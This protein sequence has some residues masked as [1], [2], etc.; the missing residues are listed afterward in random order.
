MKQNK[1]T[2]IKIVLF[3]TISIRHYIIYM[4]CYVVSW[5]HVESYQRNRQAFCMRSGKI[6]AHTSCSH[7]YQFSRNGN[8]SNQYVS[9]MAWPRGEIMQANRRI[10]LFT[11][12]SSTPCIVIPNFLS[13]G[14]GHVRKISNFKNSTIHPYTLHCT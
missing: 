3:F 1:N 14:Y 7:P 8:E 5:L 6:K 10:Y 12:A 4:L 11:L 2:C 13:Y 9:Y